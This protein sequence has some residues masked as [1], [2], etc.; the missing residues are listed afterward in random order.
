[1]RL[2]IPVILVSA[3]AAVGVGVLARQQAVN[4]PPPPPPP[5]PLPSPQRQ[6]HPLLR[7]LPPS[8][9][10]DLAGDGSLVSERTYDRLKHFA[11]YAC[12]VYQFLCPRPLGN[13]LVQHVSLYSHTLTCLPPASS[14]LSELPS[15]FFFFFFH[16]G[17]SS[18]T[19]SRMRMVSSRAMM[20]AARSS[21]RF[22][23]V[24]SSRI[25]SL[26][27]VWF[28]TELQYTPSPSFS[29]GRSC[30]HMRLYRVTHWW[31]A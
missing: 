18:R 1:M 4:E 8:E 24:T 7:P 11:K 14:V 25:W 20:D 16:L 2:S 22:G 29:S 27:C 6:Q 26:V 9:I 5:I 30:V 23:G 17:I 28:S 31:V 13:T 3:V 12:A 15:S 21:L 19:F 10:T